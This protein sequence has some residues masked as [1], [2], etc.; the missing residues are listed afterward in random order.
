MCGRRG[1]SGRQPQDEE[2]RSA[3]ATGP[4]AARH[5][6]VWLL[7]SLRKRFNGE[8]IVT[9]DDVA[10]R[11][12]HLARH[13]AYAGRTLRAVFA[14]GGGTDRDRHAV[15]VALL[16]DHAVATITRWRGHACGHS[17]KAW[18]LLWR[19]AAEAVLRM[20]ET[21]KVMAQTRTRR[22]RLRPGHFTTGLTRDVLELM[23]TK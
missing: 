23:D 5:F 1:N 10:R 18:C 2:G 12:R 13:R 6:A 4:H 16:C 8:P 17:K 22:F 14:P 3:V 11:F 9:G 15:R 20:E 19:V 7:E 21:K